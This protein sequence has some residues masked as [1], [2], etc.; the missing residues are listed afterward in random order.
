[1]TNIGC[2]CLGDS[3]CWLGPFRFGVGYRDFV[4]LYHAENDRYMRVIGF[5]VVLFFAIPAIGTSSVLVNPQKFGSGSDQIQLGDLLAALLFVG[6]WLLG[7]WL[8]VCPPL[9]FL[10]RGVVCGRFFAAHGAVVPDGGVPDGWSVSLQVSLG[11]LG[12]EEVA[13]DGTLVRT[14]YAF[15]RRRPVLTR[16]FL[17]MGLR[18]VSRESALWNMVGVNWAFRKDWN[19]EGVFVPRAVLG[20]ARGVRRGV[21]GRVR[22]GSRRYRRAVWLARLG[23]V[24]PECGR[25]AL[26]LMRPELEW[27]A[28]GERLNQQHKDDSNR[29]VSLSGA[30]FSKTDS[31]TE[32]GQA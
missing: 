29:E 9:P 2:S 5:C 13:A 16:R 6:F 19:G 11:T 22:A 21:R 27:L 23:R 1:M 28:E 3:I 18:D 31:R 24:R 10:S 8:L 12:G 14:P 26:A 25:R 17:F 15:M 30:G 7:L 32:R 20:G 4:E